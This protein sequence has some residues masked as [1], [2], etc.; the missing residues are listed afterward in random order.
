[1]KERPILFN[2][3]MVQAIREER[4]T[5]TRRVMKP[6]PP[7]WTGDLFPLS[8]G[9]WRARH[10]STVGRPSAASPVFRCPYGILGDRLWVRETWALVDGELWYRADT[11]EPERIKWKPS[12]YMPR[13]YSRIT[14]E[15]TGVRVKRV[16][17]ISV[18]DAMEEGI[19]EIPH[20]WEALPELPGPS[21]FVDAFRILWDSINTKRGFGWEANPWVWV[22]EFRNL[23]PTVGG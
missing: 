4:K 5:Q 18:G 7:D 11:D 3:P 21:H 9:K 1:M 17:D 6:Q 13:D 8:N 19:D 20:L 14:L 23:S 12:I 15:V 10:P 2:G 16:Q 22:V